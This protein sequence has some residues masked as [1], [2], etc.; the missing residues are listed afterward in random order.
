M[1]RN[2]D[3]MKKSMVIVVSVVVIFLLI[4]TISVIS[5]Y[6]SLVTGDERTAQE[7][8]TIEAR[9][10]ERHDMIGQIVATV[11]GLQEHAETIYQMITE[12]R[13]AYAAAVTSGS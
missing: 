7:F 9:L 10:Q 2:D 12:A 4:L 8:T 3:F 1:E 13:A 11:S 5:G 6:N